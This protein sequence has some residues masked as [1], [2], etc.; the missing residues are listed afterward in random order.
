[1]AEYYPEYSGYNDYSLPSRTAE[2]YPEYSGY[3]DCTLPSRTAEC[4]PEYPGYSDCAPP[5]RTAEYDPEYP[6][7]ND[8]A[9]LPRASEHSHNRTSI[10]AK[11]Q[12]THYPRHTRETSLHGRRQ[13][14]DQRRSHH[15]LNRTR[16]HSKRQQQHRTTSYHHQPEQQQ[17]Q[18][19]L[20]GNVDWEVLRL[21]VQG[22]SRQALPRESQCYGP[23]D[24]RDNGSHETNWGKPA[25]PNDHD[26]THN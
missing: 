2:Y 14:R 23:G 19:T 5:S 17:H 18:K 13:E 15:Q 11:L 10:R 1:M 25:E 9:P 22:S 4:D 6:G 7:Y 8:C 3:N 12:R 26:Q 21:A 20:L 16:S 24:Y